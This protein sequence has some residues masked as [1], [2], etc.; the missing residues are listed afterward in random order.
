MHLKRLNGVERRG[1]F[2]TL[3]G[4]DGSGKTTNGLAL[5]R[6]LTELGY[7]AVYTHEPTKALTGDYVRSYLSGNGASPYVEALLFAADRAEHI[8][9]EIIPSL[10]EGKV[11]ICDRYLS[12]SL[13]YQGA[14]GVDSQWIK[15]L[16]KCCIPPDMAFFLDID[17]GVAMSR[18]NA[19]G[20]E[21]NKFETDYEFRRRA[22]DIFT[23]LA[24]EGVLCR[25]DS[26]QGL[27]TVQA[28]IR[29]EVMQ[30]MGKKT[31]LVRRHE[32]SID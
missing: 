4:I 12:S 28:N 23:N 13:A 11:L 25:I 5:C 32:R 2:I 9:S 26:G 15:E 17:I 21:L 1:V 14:R 30:L 22:R 31:E 16:N 6:W 18:S 20:L 29:S 19:K 3:E 7:Q 10:N 8:F 24:I 27:D